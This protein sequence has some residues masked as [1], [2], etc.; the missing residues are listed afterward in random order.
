M[1]ILVV[2]A[3][4]HE[5]A[6]LLATI[7]SD[8]PR[9]SRIRSG[10]H[11]RH[12]VDVL[13]TGVGMVATATWLASALSSQRLYDLALNLGLC[14]A[15]NRGM[16]LGAVVHVT[17]DRFSELGAEDGEGFLTIH[18]LGLLGA[19]EP[20]FEG[21]AIVNHAPPVN[22][23]LQRLATVNGITVNTVH[24]N[25]ATIAAVAR[26]LQPQVES[27]EGAAFMYACAVRGVRYAQVRA[28]SNLVER[29]NRGAW[30]IGPAIDALNATALELLESA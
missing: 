25:D 28:V 22:A 9:E 3:T 11:A 8:P 24:G 7:N 14:G 27:M 26:R 15:F 6:P 19:D 30:R 18:D 13:V 1:R 5:I 23:A 21:G 29:R 20:P 16:P 12:D 17:S 4:E 2:A 10:R